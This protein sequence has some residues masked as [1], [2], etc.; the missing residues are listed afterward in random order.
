MDRPVAPDLPPPAPAPVV[1]DDSASIPWH[2][3]DASGETRGPVSFRVIRAQLRCAMLPPDA[4]VWRE[5]LD[6]W[7]EA[8]VF[9][10]FASCVEDD[11]GSGRLDATSRPA[12]AG[13][14]PRVPPRATMPNAPATATPALGGSRSPGRTLAPAA[15]FADAP[16]PTTTCLLYTSPSPRD[17]G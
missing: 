5:G 17:R 14:A 9:P 10:A 15:L 1:D 3:I 6:E 13:P 11:A 8:R 4:M 2:Y 7:C 16:P 12:T